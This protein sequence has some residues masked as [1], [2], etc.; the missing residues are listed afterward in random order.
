MA[1]LPTNQEAKWIVEDKL[2]VGEYLEHVACGTSQTSGLRLIE[3]LIGNLLGFGI[4]WLISPMN[5]AF[6]IVAA[7]D[8][9]LLLSVIATVLIPLPLAFRKAW[10]VGLTNRGL[11]VVG[12]RPRWMGTRTSVP[13]ESYHWNFDSLPTADAWLSR[14]K[15]RL[16]LSD[17]QKKIAVTFAEDWTGG[18]RSDLIEAKEIIEALTQT[19]NAKLN[20]DWESDSLN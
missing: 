20:R 14:S 6:R 7:K 12:T 2:Q 11:I 19:E 1:I 8:W 15:A 13:L 9:T 4:V 16:K 18:W 3:S 5:H 10:V 17:G